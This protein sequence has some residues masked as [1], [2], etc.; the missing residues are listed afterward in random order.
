MKHSTERIL[1]AHVGSLV[2]PIN[3]LRGMK[4]R[5]IEQPYDQQVLGED[6]RNGIHEVVR[7]QVEVGIDVPSDGEFGRAGFVNYIH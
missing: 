7:Q 5:T 4:A 2:R 3:I 6:I 1:T